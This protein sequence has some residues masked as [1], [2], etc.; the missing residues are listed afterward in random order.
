MNVGEASSRPLLLVDVDGPLN[1]YA[2]MPDHQPPGYETHRLLPA[3]WVAAEQARIAAW[4]RPGQQPVALPMWLNPGHGPALTALPFDLVWATTWEEEANTHLAPLLGLPALPFVAWA[5][6]RPQPAGGVFWKTPEIVA[7]VSGRPFAWLDDEI[8]DADHDWVAEHHSGA[9]LLRRIDP[10]LG[11]LPQDF[12]AL[13][14][15][16]SALDAR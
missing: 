16:A 1:P 7:W 11:L 13:E 2:A 3:S 5:S 15:W 14:E 12:T 8:T 10:S 9:A 4:G 6:P